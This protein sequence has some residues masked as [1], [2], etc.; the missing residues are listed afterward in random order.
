VVIC[1]RST[2]LSAWGKLTGVPSST[3]TSA[4]SSAENYQAGEASKFTGK[5]AKVTIELKPEKPLDKAQTD[6]LDQNQKLK[7]QAVE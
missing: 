3:P 5:I 2:G 4:P 7:Q 1:V 6:Q